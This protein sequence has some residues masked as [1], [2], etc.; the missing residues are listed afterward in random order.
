MIERSRFSS[1]LV[2]PLIQ[3][4]IGSRLLLAGWL[5][6]GLALEACGEPTSGGAEEASISFLRTRSQGFADL[7]VVAASG[8][9]LTQL[10]DN[11]SVHASH[12]RFARLGHQYEWSPDGE[13][14]AFAWL[15]GSGF[16]QL[17]VMD[18]TG[19]TLTYVS[20][21]NPHVSPLPMSF[22][23]CSVPQFE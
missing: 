6:S 22:S 3:G 20:D 13:K 11:T 17:R 16:Y 8:A 10:L 7:F 18:A 4:P 23:W 5:V 14:V 9:G 15:N 1:L 12:I 19:G 21:L 2:S